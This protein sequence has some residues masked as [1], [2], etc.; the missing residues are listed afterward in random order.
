MPNCLPKYSF[1]FSYDD[2]K[3]LWKNTNNVMNSQ[4]NIYCDTKEVLKAVRS[5]NQ[6][7][8]AHHLPYQGGILSFLFSHSLQ[9]LNG[10]WSDFQGKPN[11]PIIF[12]TFLRNIFQTL[13][14]LDNIYAIGISIKLL[15]A[16]FTFLRKLSF[17]LCRDEK[18]TL[19]KSALHSPILPT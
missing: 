6:E 5:E 8:L 9:K 7:R 12:P 2:V 18:Y 3:S 13:S 11:C 1:V 17:M 19:T 15:T 4:C 14:L 10:A 16:H